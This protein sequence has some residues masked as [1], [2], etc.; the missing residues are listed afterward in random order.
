MTFATLQ[1]SNSIYYVW[2]RQ[3]N[4]CS[5]TLHWLPV[6]NL[7]YSFTLSI[8]IVFNNP[9]WLANLIKTSCIITLKGDEGIF[10]FI[11]CRNWEI[12]KNLFNIHTH[13]HTL[14]DSTLSC[15]NYI[16]GVDRFRSGKILFLILMFVNYWFLFVEIKCELSPTLDL[17]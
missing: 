9:K 4:G 15:I 14:S 5:E 7:I 3:W 16:C 6:I 12:D 17:I 13:T 2:I 8:Q 1:H 10:Y 11:L